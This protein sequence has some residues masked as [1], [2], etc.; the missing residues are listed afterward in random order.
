MG[1]RGHEGKATRFKPGQSGNPAGKVKVI[2]EV[3]NAARERTLEA[4]ATLT[5]IMGDTKATAS[6][7]VTAAVALLDRGWGKPPA[8]MTLKRE[9]AYKELTDDEL[10]AIA[11]GTEGEAR[12]N[13]GSDP[14]TAP[15][16]PSKPN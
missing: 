15:G 8:I 10:I 14:A 2:I 5:A 11:A 6:A 16:D 13:G 4:I 7:R 9:G 1:F 3:V 12:T